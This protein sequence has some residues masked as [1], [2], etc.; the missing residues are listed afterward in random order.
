M[1]ELCANIPE[2]EVLV[3]LPE[4]E[5]YTADGRPMKCIGTDDVRIEL[6]REPSRVYKRV[7]RC[8]VYA[9]PRAEMETG[10]ADIHEIKR[11]QIEATASEE[12]WIALYRVLINYGQELGYINTKCSSFIPELLAQSD[13]TCARINQDIAR[14]CMDNPGY[15]YAELTLVWAAFAGIGAVY[16]W[17]KDW[18][19]LSQTT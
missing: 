7:Y 10:K 18:N 3:D 9:D 14:F 19:T 17:N 2:E 8:R 12:S 4:Q 6:V 11:A 1:E 15:N 5:K 16:H 13:Q